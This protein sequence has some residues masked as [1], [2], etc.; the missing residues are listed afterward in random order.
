MG[1]LRAN[2]Y[3]EE[4]QVLNST[5]ADESRVSSDDRFEFCI[6]AE[7]S[8]FLIQDILMPRHQYC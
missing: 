8:L 6:A 4:Y 7:M 2:K 1:D 5:Q 3:K